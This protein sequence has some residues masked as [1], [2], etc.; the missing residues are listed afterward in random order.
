[1]ADEFAEYVARC[2]DCPVRD[3]IGPDLATRLERAGVPRVLALRS[4][5]LFDAMIASRHGG[6]ATD[7]DVRSACAIVGALERELDQA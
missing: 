2:L 6:G 7:E 5:E 1:M 3:V 4:S